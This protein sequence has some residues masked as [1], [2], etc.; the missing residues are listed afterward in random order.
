[1]SWVIV[2]KMQWYIYILLPDASAVSAGQV[3]TFQ[4]LPQTQQGWLTSDAHLSKAAKH[5]LD[6]SYTDKIKKSGTLTPFWIW[7]KTQ[8]TIASQQ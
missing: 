3:Y 4:D 6:L 1:M 2:I 7:L 5:L 8:E